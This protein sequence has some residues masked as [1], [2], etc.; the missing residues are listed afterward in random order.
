MRPSRPTPAGDDISTP[1]CTLRALIESAFDLM[2]RS[3]GQKI[4]IGGIKRTSPP[5]RSSNLLTEQTIVSLKFCRGV[6][7]DFHADF[8]LANNRRDPFHSVLRIDLNW[9]ILSL[10]WVT[11]I[12]N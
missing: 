3:A 4:G 5:K 10:A 1:A 2:V 8:N 9:S 12:G 6:A 11:V 7:R